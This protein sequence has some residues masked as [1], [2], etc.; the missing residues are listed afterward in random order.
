MGWILRGGFEK[1]KLFEPS[2]K[3]T[4]RK[5]RYFAINRYFCELKKG[6]L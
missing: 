4:A 6:M 1:T 3:L 2:F 5:L